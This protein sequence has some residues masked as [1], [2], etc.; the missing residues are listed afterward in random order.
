MEVRKEMMYMKNYTFSRLWPEQMFM[1]RPV[2]GEAR[3]YRDHI[4]EEHV[5]HSKELRL[6]FVHYTETL[7]TGSKAT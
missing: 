4:T 3:I 1:K 2:K 7:K 5:C 6:Y